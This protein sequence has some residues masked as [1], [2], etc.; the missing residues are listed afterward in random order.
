[1]MPELSRKTVLNPICNP[2]LILLLLG[3][4]LFSLT[5]CSTNPATGKSQ[6][7]VLSTAEEINIGNEAAPQFLAEYGGPIPDQGI[8]Q[9]VKQM[10]ME[11]A[12]LS[13][14]PDLPWEFHVL[15]SGVINAF[16]LPGGKVFM[17][18]GLMSKMT[19]EAQLAGVL[20]HEIGHVTAQ[21]IGQQMS[22][23]M[24]VSGL[25]IA[26]GVAAQVSEKDW[27]KVLGA[28]AGAGGT[29]YLLSY[30]R[31]QEIQADTLG[32]R[33]MAKAGY[34]PVGQLQV[35]EILAEASAGAGG[36]L[37]I[38]ST[39]PLPATRIR[40]L[41]KKIK[42]DYPEYQNPDAYRFGFD[43]FQKNILEPMSKLPPPRHGAP[44]ADAKAAGAHDHPPAATAPRN[45]DWDN[46]QVVW[47]H[48]GRAL[49]WVPDGES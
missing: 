8:Q 26:A 19:N 40:E 29:L 9:Y 7:N 36:Q 20:G 5:G 37:E 46:A 27:V 24:A 6:F 18:R 28:G 49:V 31:D 13:E 38:L 23:R 2:N 30:G 11:M 1:M 22:Q 10:G 17:S 48:H 34:N 44:K 14:R 16:A 21:H 25:L 12:Q 45:A 41:E 43:T 39:H 32:V 42:S 35:M 4:L 47:S 15:D 3:A 33:Y